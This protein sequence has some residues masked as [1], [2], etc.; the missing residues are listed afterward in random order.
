MKYYFTLFTLLIG[1]CGFAQ[2]GKGLLLDGR[3]TFLSIPTNDSLNYQDGLTISAWVFPACSDNSAIVGKQHCRDYGYYL[4]L[5]EHRAL[6]SYND[7]R[8]CTNPNSVTTADITVSQAGWYHL[9]LVHTDTSV[10]IFVDGAPVATERLEGEQ[11]SIRM[12]DEPLVIGAYHFLDGSY[13]SYFSGLLDEVRMWQGAL[14]EREVALTMRS[15]TLVREDQLVLNLDMENHPAGEIAEL[16]N[17]LPG[18]SQM[19]ARSRGFS[20]PSIVPIE[21]VN[22]KLYDQLTQSN[23]CGSQFSRF[24][25]RVFED[26]NANGS[27]DEGEAFLSNV[28]V[29]I[30]AAGTQSLYTDGR[31]QF[32][33]QVLP[34]TQYVVS[35][36]SSD[37]Y[38]PAASSFT[39]YTE[40]ILT[41]PIERDIA[42]TRI[43][44]ES[45]L[46]VSVAN[47]APR[48]GFLVPFWVTVYNGGCQ[49]E[50]TFLE[51]Q[52]DSLLS[53]ESFTPDTAST[54]ADRLGWYTDDI[55]PGRK[56]VIKMMLRM[57]SEDHV[58]DTLRISA[59]TGVGTEGSARDTFSFS[60][61]LA[62][63][64]D[65]NDK[66]THPA[67][68]EPS[69]SN[70][71]QYDERITYTIRFQNTG[72]DT[73][74]TVRLL[75]TLSS[76]LDVKTFTP[77]S[78]S[79]DHS[80]SL[81]EE[82]RL[83]VLYE[84]ILLPD[85]TTNEPASH[86]Y[87]TF[88]ILPRQ[89]IRE[90]TVENRAGIYFDFNR[91][92]ITNTVI[93]T[94]V[95]Q[96]DA[97]NDGFFFFEE[98]ND[99]DPKI[100]PGAPE[101]VGNGTDEDCDG[102]DKTT[103]LSNPPSAGL[104]VYPNPT[105]GIVYLRDRQVSR[106]WKYVLFDVHGRNLHSG[107]VNG[108]QGSIVLSGHAPG[109]YILLLRDTDGQS[110]VRQLI[111]LQR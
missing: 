28:P 94:L 72:T 11:S 63:A 67:R 27:R 5:R 26:T 8:Y 6:W 49:T 66:L 108:D 47:G 84:N 40:D 42:L 62:C 68:L 73:A 77:L 1:V 59:V 30:T 93:N 71:T 110:I 52:L 35:V 37:C 74:F 64:I 39:V 106:S 80:V 96:L 23:E 101:V 89:G 91:P 61:V 105:T 100:Y 92:V 22:Q 109:T 9:A 3:G 29:T 99:F 13:G 75:D 107:R 65:P 36:D 50:G 15:D 20:A 56:K 57:P 4:G 55:E 111:T 21:D 98:C 17:N 46:L 2:S 44:G 85:S 31:G 81:D 54:N 19:V 41:A 90:G 12:S 87:F 79:H 7:E 25:G 18:G 102:T 45:E 38:G 83:S 51:L 48:C 78:A 60:T 97:D 69:Q 104:E 34:D 43:P 14:S 70:Y 53:V 33:F 95:E 82:G 32:S 86:G 24:I 16:T 103:G 58:G 10:T 76:L 88:S